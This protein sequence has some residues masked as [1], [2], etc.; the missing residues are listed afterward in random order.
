VGA[1]RKRLGIPGTTAISD[2][3][4][5]R[6][7]IRRVLGS[8]IRSTHLSSGYLSVILNVES[9][10][11]GGAMEPDSPRGTGGIGGGCLARFPDRLFRELFRVTELFDVKVRVL[12][13]GIA[14]SEPKLES[15][16]NLFLAK[17]SQQ[18]SQRERDNTSD[19][20]HQTNDSR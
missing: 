12:E 11:V 6:G 15:W 8:G 7:I 10:A 4:N 18:Q 1:L 2:M 14:Q 17:R 3:K 13:R 16:G 19:V 20:R 5:V 9:Y